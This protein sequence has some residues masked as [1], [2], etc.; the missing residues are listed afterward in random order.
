MPTVL[1]T[2]SYD[3]LYHRLTSDKILI[4]GIDI[5]NT[6]TKD[7]LDSIILKNYSEDNLSLLPSCQCG[8]L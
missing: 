8:E 6:E 4:N 5:F 1:K 7:V 3:Q 2:K